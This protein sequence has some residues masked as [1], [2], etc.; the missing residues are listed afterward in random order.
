MG[1]CHSP[2]IRQGSRCGH[3][4]VAE[5][6]AGPRASKAMFTKQGLD[7]APGAG[8]APGGGDPWPGRQAVSPL[9]H[10]NWGGEGSGR[11]ELGSRQRAVW[12]PHRGPRDGVGDQLAVHRPALEAGSGRND[13]AVRPCPA[14]LPHAAGGAFLRTDA[15]NTGDRHRVE[16]G[17]TARPKG[18]PFGLTNGDTEAQEEKPLA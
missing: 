16:M 10:G 9:P 15:S 13:R 5:L 11:G 3:C 4:E 18:R 6:A 17:E 8:A 1:L 12:A 14:S 2:A 7:L